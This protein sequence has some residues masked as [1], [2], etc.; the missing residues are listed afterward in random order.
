VFGLTFDDGFVNVAENAVPVLADLG[1]TA[2]NYFVAAQVGGTNAWDAEKGVPTARLMDRAQVRAWARAG[3]E[4]GSHTIAHVNLK[5]CGTD[6]ARRQIAGSRE[7]LQDISGE[8]VDAFC[9][10]YGY[11]LAEQCALVR[12]AGY[13]SA[14]TTRRGRVQPGQDMMELSRVHVLRSTHF[15]S[16]MIKMFTPRE[17]VRGR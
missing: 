4:V 13:T 5:A 11:Y 3:H 15:V 14:T 17:E 9:Y 2:T 1:F 16:M 6:E 7:M 12:D 10:P 8:S